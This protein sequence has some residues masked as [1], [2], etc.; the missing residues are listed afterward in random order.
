MPLM[1]MGDVWSDIDA[2]SKGLIPSQ[3]TWKYL[4]PKVSESVSKLIDARQYVVNYYMNL[5][6]SKANKDRAVNT[7]NLLW[8][9]TRKN[10]LGLS[11]WTGKQYSGLSLP[12]RIKPTSTKQDL[13]SLGAFPVVVGL[14]AG[15]IAVTSIAA[16]GAVV[17]W[18]LSRN[19]QM[20]QWGKMTPEAQRAWSAPGGPGTDKGPLPGFDLGS[21]AKAIPWVVGGIAAIYLLPLITR[22][23]PKKQPA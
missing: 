1:Y 5:N 12:P 10:I 9:Q 18:T 3:L 22:V 8:D 23:I 15:G 13:S 20:W 2:L 11:D 21:I 14:I 19:I 7:Y 6:V 16:F 17:M 4:N